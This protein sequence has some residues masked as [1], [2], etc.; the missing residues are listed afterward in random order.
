VIVGG[1]P[2]GLG[3][4]I[5]L[6][7]RGVPVLVLEKERSLHHVPKGQNLTQRT[8]E[9]FRFWGVEK[10]IRSAR[11][12]PPGYPAVGVN[13]YGDLM[14]DHAHPWFRRSTVD[15]YYFTGNERLPQYETETV[16][17]SR[18]EEIPSIAVRYGTPV[19]LIDQDDSAVVVTT[20]EGP[21]EG[22][23]AVGCDGSHSIV[24]Q[25]AGF[26]EQRSD[27]DRRMALLVFRSRE[28]HDLL[29]ER[30]GQASF[31]NVL[32]PDLDGYWRFLGRVDVA[33]QWFFHAPVAPDATV[34]NL[35]ARSLVVATVGA[36]VEIDLDYVGFWDLRF[37]VADTYGQG[38]I[39]IAG[40]AAHSHP[41]YG[42]YGINLGLEDVRNLG[43][44]L[45]AIL[46]GWGGESLLSSYNEERR[47]VF[48]STAR[49]FI[50]A[51]IEDDRTFISQ[52]DPRVDEA[53]FADAWERRGAGSNRGVSEFEPHYEG[54][55]IVFGP[56]DG[57]SGAVG[58]HSFTARAGH[59]LPPAETPEDED[60]FRC[61][62]TGFSLVTADSRSSAAKSFTSA[63]ADRGVPLRIVAAEMAGYETSHVL[64]RPDHF[65]SWVDDGSPFDPSTIIARSIGD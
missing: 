3:L 43:W 57:V 41:P 52:H 13:A 50:E 20:P 26:G 55:P 65:V 38:R 46:E 30:Y 61:L 42:G 51:F 8:M 64:V 44:K 36:D 56:S 40:D 21:I 6:G 35:D 22:E 49:D 59:H 62:G 31:F 12:M 34:D 33:E 45:A 19:S 14:S 24:R 17:R 16:L 10:A 5:E 29:Q 47:P 60:L 63:S 9:H 58:S 48:V 39:F 15:P 11:V 32:H 1:G 2:V 7:Q 53:G 4:A 54:S 25:Q 23:Y 18:V 37:A 28:L 27:H